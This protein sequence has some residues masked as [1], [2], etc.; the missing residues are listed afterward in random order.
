M[1]FGTPAH[2]LRR[3]NDP[4]TSHEAAALVNTTKL[5]KDVLEYIIFQGQYGATAYECITHFKPVS[6]STIHAR[7]SALERKGLIYYIGDTRKGGSG[8]RQR[9][10]RFERRIGKQ[11][12]FHKRRNT[13]V[14]S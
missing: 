14:S 9:I 2:T 3:N 13:E 12:C 6:D 7:P 5:E 1:N 11:F 10:M 4:I 8:R